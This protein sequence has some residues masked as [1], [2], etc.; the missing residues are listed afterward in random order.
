MAVV[1]QL[2]ETILVVDDEPAICSLVKK[3]LEREG[4][5]VLIAGDAETATHIYEEHSAEVALLLTDVKMPGM[6]GLE[7]ADRILRKKPQLRVLFMSGS[8]G[9]TGGLACIAK[10]FTRAQ[11]IGRVGMALYRLPPARAQ[12]A[13]AGIGLQSTSPRIF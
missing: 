9:A 7:L 12:V 6:N 1:T 10:P 13:A 8:P 11:L 3:L 2:H 4:Y 5:A